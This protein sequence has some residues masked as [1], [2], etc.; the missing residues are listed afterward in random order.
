M[1]YF[2]QLSRYDDP[3]KREIQ[4]FINATRNFLSDLL[5]GELKLTAAQASARPPLLTELGP[6]ALK[7]FR[8]FVD[9]RLD[10][11]HVSVQWAKPE[12]LK[13]AGVIGHEQALRYRELAV[14]EKWATNESA[15]WR[16]TAALLQQANLTLDSTLEPI[17]QLMPGSDEFVD[18]FK[19]YRLAVFKLVTG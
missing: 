12:A 14:L 9:Q 11:L 8:Q 2:T 6:D 18:M 13:R 10:E 16:Q 3:G 4:D 7:V 19:Q 15:D 17:K 1:A 5:G